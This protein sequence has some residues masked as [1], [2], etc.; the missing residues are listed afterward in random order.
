MV[1]SG[2]GMSYLLG[3]VVRQLLPYKDVHLV[4][5]E[6][7]SISCSDKHF[8]Q[9]MYIKLISKLPVYNLHTALKD[10]YLVGG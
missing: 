3:I 9:T 8:M 4:L 10:D 6:T 7:H 1:I 2:H 5:H